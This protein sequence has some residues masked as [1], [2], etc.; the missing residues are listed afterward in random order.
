MNAIW[1]SHYAGLPAEG[2]AASRCFM[3][4]E[5]V[6]WAGKR[7]LDVGCRR[8]KGVFKLSERVGTD[9]Y[10]VGVD[11]RP[12]FVNAARLAVPAAL[13]RSGLATSNMEFRE[14]FPEDLAAAGL[15][16]ASFDVVYLNNVCVLFADFPRV[17]RE[18]ARVLVPDGLLVM[19]APVAAQNPTEADLVAAYA[20]G[21]SLKA[22]R[23]QQQLESWLSQAGFCRPSTNAQGAPSGDG[24][25]QMVILHAEKAN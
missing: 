4:L 22:A 7:V 5:G 21:D 23:T 15:A 6:T 12:D 20:E 16:D 17:L 24:E 8:G 19:E 13:R 9:G 18:C 2:G 25:A 1:E 11:W 14:A 10:V 3:A